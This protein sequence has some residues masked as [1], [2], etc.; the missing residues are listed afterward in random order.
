MD[1]AVQKSK[2]IADAFFLSEL[3]IWIFLIDKFKK[4]SD[5]LLEM[6]LKVSSTKR[7][8]I[9]GAFPGKSFSIRCSKS[10]M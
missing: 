1:K 10:S 8:Q 5:S 4:D 7:S 3:Y 6:M 9:L 2:F